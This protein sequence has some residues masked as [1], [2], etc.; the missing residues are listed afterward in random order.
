MQFLFFFG[1][2]DVYNYEVRNLNREAWTEARCNMKLPPDLD[3]SR[4]SERDT[5]TWSKMLSIDSFAQWWAVKFR[6]LKMW[7]I[8]AT[9]EDSPSMIAG[10]IS[11]SWRRSNVLRR[12]CNSQRRAACENLGSCIWRSQILMPSCKARASACSPEEA[13]GENA[14]I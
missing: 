6:V 13:G 8:L 9:Q 1:K 7:W 11:V 10:L 5:N 3:R 14:E 2:S 4:H 12:S